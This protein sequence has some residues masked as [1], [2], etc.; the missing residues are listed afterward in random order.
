MPNIGD[1]CDW[2]AASTVP[3]D[4]GL[5]S[6]ESELSFEH[7]SSEL[8]LNLINVTTT[9]DFLPAIS[10]AA[11]AGNIVL[12]KETTSVLPKDF[13][14]INRTPF[15]PQDKRPMV[16]RSSRDLSPHEGF[17]ENIAALNVDIPPQTPA[18]IVE[19]RS[20]KSRASSKKRIKQ[21]LQRHRLSTMDPKPADPKK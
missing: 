3:K 18:M 12:I 14:Q 6:Q 21:K 2:I 16:R 19:A 11:H 5:S 1:E 9:S 20:T 4:V 15:D 17:P 8:N 7:K 13:S 10:G